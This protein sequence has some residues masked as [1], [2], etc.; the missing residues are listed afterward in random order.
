MNK[1]KRNLIMNECIN[2]AKDYDPQKNLNT[3]FE[4]L[5]IILEYKLCLGGVKKLIKQCINE[6]DN[7]PSVFLFKVLVAKTKKEYG[8]KN[9]SNI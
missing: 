7:Y 9:D 2:F 8:I 1:E 3:A 6:L 4:F 5:D